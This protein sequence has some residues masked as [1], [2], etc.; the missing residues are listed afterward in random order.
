MARE[1]LWSQLAASPGAEVTE[2]HWLPERLFGC[3]YL[4]DYK[5]HM[6]FLKWR[7]D[8]ESACQCRNY[9]R[10]G[11]DPGLGR[12]PGEGNGNPP[13][14]SCLEKSH[15]QRSLMGCCPWGHKE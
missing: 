15:G 4:Y 3:I 14:H 1:T 12:S 11:F 2:F 10:Y 5:K 7:H 9:R 13:Q 6:G 8:R